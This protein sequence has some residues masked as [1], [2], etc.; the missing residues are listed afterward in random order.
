MCVRVVCGGRGGRQHHAARPCSRAPPHCSHAAWAVRNDK[1]ADFLDGVTVS[2]V[3]L[4]GIVA[5]ELLTVSVTSPVGAV[6]FFVA[7]GV[8]LTIK[9]GYVC[10]C[11]EGRAIG[12]IDGVAQRKVHTT[13]RTESFLSGACH[14]LVPLFLWLSGSHSMPTSCFFMPTFSCPSPPPAPVHHLD[15][16]DHDGH[17]RPGRLPRCSGHYRWV[18]RRVAPCLGVVRKLCCCL[19]AMNSI[20][21]ISFTPDLHVRCQATRKVH[22]S[23]TCKPCVWEG[24]VR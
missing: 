16:G 21:F 14:L 8:V 4:I 6:F 12:L 10:V 7:L 22:H 1:L 18:I 9:V 19:R 11:W 24:G 5:L 13:S 17:R 15:I 20:I 3:G 2:V 23:G